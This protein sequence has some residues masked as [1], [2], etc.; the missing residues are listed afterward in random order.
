M[1]ISNTLSNAASGTSIASRIVDVEAALIDAAAD[2]SSEARL[3]AL[4]DRFAT[5]AQSLNRA[6]DQVQALRV[7]A[8]GAIADQVDQLNSALAQVQRINGD[9]SNA[10]H[11]R[12]D[13][14]SLMD[15]RQQLV[16]Q[17]SKI[18]PVRELDRDRGQ[19][20]LMTPQ[21]EMLLDSVATVFEF[22][23][24]AVITADMTFD[25]G[26]LK[27]ILKDGQP[28]A[29]DDIG[30]LSGGT[31]GAAFQARDTELVNAQNGLDRIAADLIMRFQ[32][33]AVDPSLA[34]GDAGILTDAGLP[35]QSGSID[36]LAGRLAINAA[37]DPEQG[38]Q[39]S[40]LRDGLNATAQG[41]SGDASRLLA[42][43]TAMTTA[44]TAGSD[45]F[46]Q[47]AASRASTFEAIIGAAR[48]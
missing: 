29:G 10:R 7:G 20:A 38:G 37:I 15:L 46:T 5:L 27:G 21:G 22:T 47:T 31:L 32:D 1:S 41:L 18:I 48:A 42:L 17:I 24:V 2:P 26:G 28:I 23:H 30:K 44:Q 40:A 3:T 39:V 43:S 12:Q 25:S 14:S 6:S 45:D 35:Y 19:I 13:P 36:G 4:A 11:T 34:V 9:I 8:D 33:P 16:D